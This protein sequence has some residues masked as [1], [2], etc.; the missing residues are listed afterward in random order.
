[1]QDIETLIEQARAAMVCPICGRHFA[2]SEIICKGYLDHTYL[3]HASCSYNHETVYTTW[4]TSYLP[5]RSRQEVTPINTDN[6]VEL[7]AALQK[8]S[9]DFRSLWTKER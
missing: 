3:L 8:F 6:V 9:G 5:P 4:V 7:H 1:M 2:K